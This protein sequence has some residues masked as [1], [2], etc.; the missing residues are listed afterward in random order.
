MQIIEGACEAQ[1]NLDDNRLVKNCISAHIY[2]SGPVNFTSDFG[3]RFALHPTIFRM[4]GSAKQVSL[5]AKRVASVLDALFLTSFGSRGAS[6][7]FEKFGAQYLILCSESDNLAKI[8]VICNFAQHFQD[9]GAVV[10]L[11]KWNRSPHVAICLDFVPWI[12]RW[13]FD[14]RRLKLK[15]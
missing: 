15:Y 13:F 4:P 11:V 8:S 6:K 3:A 2:D 12:V 10:K 7:V 5:V 1:L 14:K 9:L